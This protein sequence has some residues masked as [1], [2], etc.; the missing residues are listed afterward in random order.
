[1]SERRVDRY[2]SALLLTWAGLHLLWPL[3]MLPV[4]DAVGGEA[5]VAGVGGLLLAAALSAE[6]Y[7]RLTPGPR[8]AVAGLELLN[9]G[10]LLT[11]D[12]LFLW[13]VSKGAAG[14]AVVANLLVVVVLLDRTL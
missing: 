7:G 3:A 9:V 10:M 1:M 4:S 5:I 2:G 8:L 11:T 14:A 13:P 12:G 6:A